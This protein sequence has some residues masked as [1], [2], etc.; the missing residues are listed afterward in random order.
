MFFLK[1]VLLGFGALFL[2]LLGGAGTQSNSTLMQGSGVLGLII[3]LIVLYIF[4][5]MAWRAMGCLPSLFL[6]AAIIVFILYAIG[7]FNGGITNVGHNLKSFMGQ[8]SLRQNTRIAS[9]SGTNKAVVSLLDEEEFDTP[10]SEN[11]SAPATNP[12]AAPQIVEQHSCPPECQQPQQQSPGRFLDSLFGGDKASQAETVAFNPKN[13][14]AVYSEAQVVSG[15]TLILG[16]HYFRLYG[17]DAPENNQQ[18]SDAVG[19]SYSCGRQAAAWLASWL[20]D[21]VLE[22]RIMQRDER[23]N[24]VGVCSLGVYDLGAAL[25]NAGWAVAYTK[26]TDIYAPYQIQAQ[27]NQRGLWQGEF[28]MPW[29]WR[30]IQNRKANIKIIKSQPKRK[31]TLLG[32]MS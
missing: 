21:N 9:A 10:I 31:R 18:C 27:E 32:K 25:V 29:D 2:I 17:I 30:K 22:C 4:A 5:K 13:F 11:F 26:Y 1:K 20:Q 19:R 14:P 16:N 6:I 8:N 24:M 28:Y 3:G 12:Q 15:D 7:A 23:G